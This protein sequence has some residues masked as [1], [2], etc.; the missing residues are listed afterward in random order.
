MFTTRLITVL[1]L[2]VGVM[3][4]QQAPIKT[5]DDVRLGMQR[6]VL[7]AALEK[8]FNIH[9]VGGGLEDGDWIVSPKKPERLEIATVFFLL[10]RVSMIKSS[11]TEPMRREAVDF[12]E[13][14][15]LLL[16]ENSRLDPEALAMV[17]KPEPPPG[18]A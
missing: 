3:V 16:R 5:L 13:R 18:L 10:D 2:L 14:L 7:L 15:F 11:L 9:P 4:G 1:I 8:N 17:Q 12:G 6:K